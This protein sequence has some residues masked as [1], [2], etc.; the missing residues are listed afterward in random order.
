MVSL[1]A[2]SLQELPHRRPGIRVFVMDV[3]GESLAVFVRE[4]PPN[5]RRKV[6]GKLARLSRQIDSASSPPKAEKHSRNY[7][8]LVEQAVTRQC[9][10]AAPVS[11]ME[12]DGSIIAV[13]PD[14]CDEGQTVRL[15]IEQIGY[16]L[17]ALDLAP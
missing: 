3:D 8:R 2:D 16:L 4:L 12:L 11:A 9:L 10:G 17:V 14:E 15:S 7:G 1:N 13:S 5:V 6:K